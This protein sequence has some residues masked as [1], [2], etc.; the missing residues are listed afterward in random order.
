[1][2]VLDLVII[3]QSDIYP[4]LVILCKNFCSHSISLPG[5]LIMWIEIQILIFIG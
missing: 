2:Y 1:M 5:I 4:V 3:E